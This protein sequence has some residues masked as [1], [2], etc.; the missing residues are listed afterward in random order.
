[1]TILPFPTHHQTHHQH[2]D[3]V[4]A[5]RD[6]AFDLHAILTEEGIA[7]SS[8]ETD[9]I[10]FLGKCAFDDAFLSTYRE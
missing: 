9:R 3:R 1:M 5:P 4:Y 2:D 6:D 10:E 8:F 7:I